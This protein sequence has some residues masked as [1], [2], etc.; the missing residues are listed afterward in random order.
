MIPISPRSSSTPATRGASFPTLRRAERER[1]IV[2]AFLRSLNVAF[3]DDEISLGNAEPVDVSF[4]EARFQIMEIVGDKK[5]GLDWKNREQRYLDAKEAADLVEPY[6]P[7]M[8]IS[9]ADISRRVAEGLVPKSRHYRA[10]GTATVD[11]LVYVDLSNAHLYPTEPQFEPDVENALRRQNWRSVSMLFVPYG[12]VLAA[13]A[14]APRF[15]LETF[16]RTPQPWPDPD[17]LS[18]HNVASSRNPA[19]RAPSGHRSGG[20]IPGES[21]LVL[22]ENYIR[23]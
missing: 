20:I 6:T 22:P 9:F 1:T 4:R 12:V 2:R 19:T 5:R 15:L 7:S 16:G 13:S 23:A 3:A 14:G 8:P 10:A 21:P 18:T 11:A 17:G